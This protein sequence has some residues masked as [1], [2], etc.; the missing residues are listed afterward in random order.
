MPIALDK[1]LVAFL[2]FGVIMV[3]GIIVMSDINSHYPTA[4]VNVN[5]SSAEEQEFQSLLTD[6]EDLSD[7]MQE[8]SLNETT[9][10]TD[11]ISNLVNGA[12]KAVKLI[13]T[14]FSAIPKMLN[15]FALKLGINPI[16]VN[17]A[18]AALIALV[19]IAL[20]YLFMRIIPGG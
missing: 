5:L 8:R 19:A 9:S 14:S 7:E 15:I 16:F 12:Y 10:T 1:Y 4:N 3:G 6:F 17:A 18:T 11:A 13:G 20:I 2:I